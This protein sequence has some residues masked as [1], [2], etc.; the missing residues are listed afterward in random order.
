MSRSIAVLGLGKF[1]R[2]L[3]E[4]L[5]TQGMDM[6]VVDKNPEKIDVKLEAKPVKKQ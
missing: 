5:Y 4:G 3:A 6:M 1:G 2:S